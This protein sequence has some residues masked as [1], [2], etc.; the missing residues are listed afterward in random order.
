[1]AQ[2]VSDVDAR[3]WQKFHMELYFD[4]TKISEE[5]DLP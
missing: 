3:K 5:N 2:G 4:E 1:M